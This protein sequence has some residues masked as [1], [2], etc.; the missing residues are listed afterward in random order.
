[1]NDVDWRE[2]DQHV[3]GAS[4]AHQRLLTALDPPEG[5]GLTDDMV[6]RPSRLPGW[7]VG[8]VLAHLALNA[9]SFVSVI[10][11]AERGECVR[12]YTSQ[13]TRDDDIERASRRSASEHVA[14]LRGAVYRLEGTWSG[15]REAWT[16]AGLTIGGERL[17]V[18]EIPMRRWREVEV[19]M[20]DLGLAEVSLDSIELWSNEY[21]RHDLRRL[22]MSHKARGSMGLTGLPNAVAIRPPRER[23]AWMLGRLDIEGAP[24]G[25]WP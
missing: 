13:E 4:S 8:H 11:A 12:Q 24:R 16:G 21:V 23:L 22:E 25:E 18:V 17:P 2:I 9:E 20:A 10:E 15:A 19:H 5:V 1:M 14:A 6:S 7:T 3:A